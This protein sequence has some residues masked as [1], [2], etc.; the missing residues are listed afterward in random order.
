MLVQYC[1]DITVIY[2]T[3]SYTCCA[4]TVGLPSYC[5]VEWPG[6]VYSKSMTNFVRRI[7]YKAPVGGNHHH[8]GSDFVS[9]RESAETTRNLKFKKTLLAARRE[10]SNMNA[11]VKAMNNRDNASKQYWFNHKNI[12]SGNLELINSILNSILVAI[13]HCKLWSSVLIRIHS[14]H[15]LATILLPCAYTFCTPVQHFVWVW[16]RYHSTLLYPGT[17]NLPFCF[18]CGHCCSCS[19]N[20]SW[21][22]HLVCVC[23]LLL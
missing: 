10:R 12:Q 15:S 21:R 16:S 20:Y 5:T 2:R 6:K 14:S 11:N 4:L 13:T 22:Q 17:L 1:T 7:W 19:C 8:L 9:E 23:P 18:L 3:V